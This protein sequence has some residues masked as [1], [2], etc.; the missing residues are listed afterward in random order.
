META[1]DGR[2]RPVSTLAITRY[3]GQSIVFG[4]PDGGTMCI[5][6]AELRSGRV[7]LRISA[8]LDIK[9]LRGEL[10]GVQR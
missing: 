6:V 5:D 8:P 9:I 2:Q 10:A 1:T 7:R 4:F 3:E